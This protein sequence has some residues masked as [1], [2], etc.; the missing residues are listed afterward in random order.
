MSKIVGDKPLPKGKATIRFEFTY[1]G[2][3][4]GKGG[5]GKILVNGAEAASGKVDRTQGYRYKLCVQI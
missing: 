5:V 1:D 2:G 4:I 3:G